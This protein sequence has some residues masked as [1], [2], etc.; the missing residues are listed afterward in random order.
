MATLDR[1]DPDGAVRQRNAELVANWSTAQARL[2]RSMGLAGRLP[3][4]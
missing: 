2:S 1:I 4:A 3:S